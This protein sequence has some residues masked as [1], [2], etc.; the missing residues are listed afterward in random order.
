MPHEH[1]KREREGERKINLLNTYKGIN[2]NQSLHACQY[3]HIENVSFVYR[4][5]SS[6][7]LIIT[8]HLQ[9]NSTLF[10]LHLILHVRY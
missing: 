1:R 10:C 6:F 7:S 3:Q 2:I 8:S 5:I 4:K 9:M